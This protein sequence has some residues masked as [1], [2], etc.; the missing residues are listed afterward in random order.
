MNT[1]DDFENERSRL[2]GIAY[3]MLG[4]VQDAEDIVQEAWLRWSAVDHAVEP[5]AYLTTITTRLAIDRLRSAQ[6]SR[7][8]YV[9]PWLPEPI[10]TDKD[11]AHLVE[12]DESV[13]LGFLHV[14]ERLNPLERAVFLLHD[15]FGASFGEIATT[16]GRTDVACRQIAHRARLR[17]RADHLNRHRTG[18]GDA[19]LVEQLREALERG[20]VDGVARLVAPDVVLVSDGGASTHAARRPV[21]GV[22]RVT[23]LLSNLVD[24]I[25]AGTTSSPVE[26]NGSAGL[27]L[28]LDGYLGV[29]VEAQTSENRIT[30]IHIV[31]A[32]DKLRAA[33]RTLGMQTIPVT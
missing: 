2:F 25:P 23:R 27:V 16:V 11:P 9:G 19:S 18:G 28:H 29:L 12:L 31:T 26:V 17:V 10:L 15:V 30:Q 14:L 5:A 13:T 24:R 32:P 8:Q 4:V 3:R 33:A 20:D 21:V 6:R 7:E 22:D 1:T